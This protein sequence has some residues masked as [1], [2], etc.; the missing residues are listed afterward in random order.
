MRTSLTLIMLIIVSGCAST[1]PNRG[2]DFEG[3]GLTP[4]EAQAE[5]K[6][7]A[8]FDRELAEQAQAKSRAKTPGTS[9]VDYVKAWGT[10]DTTEIMDGKIVYGY[11]GKKPHFAVFDQGKLN[12]WIIDRHTVEQRANKSEQNDER[13]SEHLRA[14]F[15]N[16]SNT[17]GNQKSQNN[18]GGQSCR[19]WRPMAQLGCS[20]VCINDSWA[21]VCN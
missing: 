1:G 10:P 21:Q 2:C 4:K 20:V 18:S 11:L 8:E 12:S 13:R 16:M 6:E 17:L 7:K 9:I 5:A 15:Q 3:C 14:A 19:N